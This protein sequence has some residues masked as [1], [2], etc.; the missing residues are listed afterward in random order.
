MAFLHYG[1]NVGNSS[2]YYFM[3]ALIYI[4]LHQVF[5]P[6]FRILKT[7][8]IMSNLQIEIAHDYRQLISLSLFFLFH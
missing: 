1:F 6:S 3:L 2:T 4:D 5:F 8:E 7:L